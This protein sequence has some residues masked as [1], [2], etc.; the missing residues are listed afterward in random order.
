MPGSLYHK[1]AQKVTDWLSLDSESKTN[2]STKKT[3]ESLKIV[4]LDVDE[5][6][7]SF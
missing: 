6:L 2:S 7:M 5:V 4:T 1:I 3:V